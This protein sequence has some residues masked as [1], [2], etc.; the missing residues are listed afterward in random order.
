MDCVG[1]IAGVLGLWAT[2]GPLLRAGPEA[3]GARGRAECALAA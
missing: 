2:S 3:L 1:D